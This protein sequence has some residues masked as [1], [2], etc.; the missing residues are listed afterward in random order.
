MD[1]RPIAVFDSG[2]GGLTV[3]AELRRK[4]PAEHIVYF[5]DTARVPYGNKSDETVK[6]FTHQICNFLLRLNPKCIVAACNTVS[7]VALPELISRIGVPAVGVVEPGAH[8]A[9]LAAPKGG[10]IAVVATEATVGSNA[11]RLAIRKTN[12]N[13]AVIQKACPLFVPLVEEGRH[14]N[15][16]LVELAVAD[17]LESVRQLAPSVLVLGCTHYPILRDTLARFFRQNITIIDSAEQTAAAV[18]QLLKRDAAL[19][20]SDDDGKLLCYVSDNPLRFETIGSRFLGHAVPHVVRI[21]LDELA[22]T[23]APPTP[24]THR[25]TA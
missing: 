19:S 8:A 25:A 12:P 18:L 22:N 15:D 20:Q 1:E 4:L 16:K 3:V 7:A 6:R 5:G 23:L 24:S 11:Y 9:A 2:I 13:L 14:P 10:L 17:Y 21:D